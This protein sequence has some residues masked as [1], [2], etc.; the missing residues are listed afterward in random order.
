MSS[1]SRLF[2][3]GTSA[4]AAVPAVTGPEE[5]ERVE[6]L[7]S[8]S[9]T[10][11][12]A[13]SV[14][15][16]DT[17]A[18]QAL[19]GAR[20]RAMAMGSGPVAGPTRIRR[21]G[22]TVDVLNVVTALLAVLA[23]VLASVTAWIV[24][25][26]ASP[27]TDALRTLSQSEAVLANETQ[28]VNAAIGRVDQSRA[29]GIAVAQQFQLPLAQLVGM[30]DDA[31]LASAEKGRADYLAALEALVVP[32]PVGEFALPPVDEESLTSIG[33]AIDGVSTRSTEVSEVA[34]SVDDLRSQLF[35][36]GRTFAA[37]MAAFAAT[38]PASAQ[39]IIDENP[40][41]DESFREAVTQTADAVA[42]S[43]LA[44]PES[45]TLLPAYSTAVTALR[46]D[47][48]RAEEEIAERLAR[49]E[50]ERRRQEQQ[51]SGGGETD[52]TTPTDPTAP[53]DPTDPIEPTDPGTDPPVEPPADPGQ[54]DGS[55]G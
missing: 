12:V 7:F 5:S 29:D 44:T 32:A 42:T 33:A 52:P 22:N 24:I 19:V 26:S 54:G 9:R 55:G 46:D 17:P 35:T 37:A 3:E 36:L 51:Q 16:D 18:L 25:A 40:D 8:K 6:R 21:A 4:Q 41:A 48:L 20:G 30:S 15:L 38:V 43:A 53:T 34:E 45:V 11:D 13:A 39:T 10:P 2:P 49:E 47:Q 27:E 31:A 23:L 50:E 14:P 28:A 1:L